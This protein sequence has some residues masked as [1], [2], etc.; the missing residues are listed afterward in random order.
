MIVGIDLGF[1]PRLIVERPKLLAKLSVVTVL[2]LNGVLLRCY[3]FPRI[4][5]RREPSA[6]EW[7]L[8]MVCGAVSTSSWLMAA[9]FGI[10]RPLQHWP[11]KATLGLYG[12][13]L[14][15]A[16]VVALP[17]AALLRRPLLDA[18]R[19]LRGRES[20]ERARAAPEKAS[21][22][23]AKRSHG[24]GTR[25]ASATTRVRVMVG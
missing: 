5:G 10:A 9:F 17:A 12:L 1:D 25:Q 8:V 7:L 13:V 21:D 23:G 11:A 22:P 14:I 4:S 3:C 24:S 20:D 6:L 2:S 18:A 15:S 19:G 16:S